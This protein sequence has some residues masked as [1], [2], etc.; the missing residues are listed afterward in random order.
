MN[1]DYPLEK[2]RNFGIIAHIDA[3]KTTTSERVLFY[4]GV[5]HKIGEV[6]EGQAI[7]DWMEQEKERGITITS[8]ATTCFWVPTYEEK[9]D[10]SKKHRFNII[11]TPGHVDFTVE[12]ERSLKVLDGGVV[13][14]DG[15]AGVEPQSETVWRQADKYKVPR[16]CFINKLDRMGGSFEK[17]FQ[18]ILKR[19]TKNAVR[20]QI[21][22]GEE[23]SFEAIIDLLR[24]KTYYF[25]GEMGNTLR[26]AEIPES[27][28]AD[29][30]KY[31]A[32]LVEKIVENDE[33]L[34]SKYLDGQ[35]IPI[36]DLKTTLRKAVIEN[37]IVPVF[38]GSALKNKGVQLVLDAVID[39]LPSP[40]DV[41]PI[42]GID[43]KTGEEIDRKS[44]DSE[45]FAALAFKLQTDP[46]VGQ[47]TYFRVYSGIISSG[48]YVYN[49][50]TGEKERL[51]RILRMHANERE[52]VK[53]VFAGEIA[54]AVGLRNAKTGDTL[55]DENKQIILE[56]IEFPEPVISLRVEPKTK[57]D[58]EKMGIALKRLSD[59]DPTFRVKSDPET[60]ETVIMGMGELHLE[61]LVDRMKR[62][63]SVETS[64]GKPQVAYKETIT[65]TAE[66]ENKYI[67]QTGGR[68]QYGHVKIVLK[69]LGPAPEKLPKNIKR[70]EGFE[71][72]DSIKGGV[73]PQE[74]IPA[75]EKGVREA[76][77]RGVVAGYKMT[78]VSCE[79]TFGSYHDVDSSEIAYK[80]AASQAFQ[81]AAKKA[82]PVLLEPIM[83][84]EVVVPEKFM[85]DITGNLNSKRGQIDSMED[86]GELKSIVAKVP[87]SEMF[88]YVT[89][90]RSMTE[91]R[92]T[93][94][95]E[96]DHYE[97]VPP[98][99]A[100]E[101]IESRK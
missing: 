33:L 31:H 60:G 13:V 59:E 39:Y 21:P 97:I 36:S 58:Q 15:V 68:G 20:M 57:A 62:E 19:L 53:T 35:E 16:I 11:D 51:G 44:S 25:E 77:E 54:A 37:K 29:A 42:K 26:E 66:V 46:Y 83:K 65:G 99:V 70:E 27:H 24:M 4:T 18:S 22:I 8:A 88:G 41:P 30:L 55:C 74:F 23:S 98:N 10:Q 81:E 34:M 49:S 90:L 101:I 91:G 78:D 89:A 85:G 73:I 47:L 95:M 3:G 56:K 86:K 40:I 50:T 93:A 2:V 9:S 67:K 48:S 7:M 69:P 100:Q 94:M 12:V 72:I 6:H 14:F 52:E 63:F 80:I 96:F 76:M 87:L 5:S 43:P 82:K 45:P 61:I 1:R 92:G 17:S 28:K 32:E 79:L 84:V 38:T 75:V 71:F 64:V